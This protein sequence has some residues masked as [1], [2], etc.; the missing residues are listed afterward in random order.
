[1]EEMMRKRGKRLA[2]PAMVHPNAW[3]L[4]MGAAEM[5]ACVPPDRQGETVRG[6]GTFTPDVHRLA[7]GLVLCGVDRVAMESTG[8][9]GVP[10]FEILEA[11]GLQGELVNAQH[12]K[13][14][15]GRKREYADCPWIQKLHA[16]GFLTGS[17]RPDAEMG[18]LRVSLRHR[19]PLSE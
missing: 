9:Y 13:N 17:F 1:M 4:D 8:I 14:V 2:Q 3:G 10:I 18:R 12:I 6:L 16:V 7:D 15:P 11:R 19:A 5:W